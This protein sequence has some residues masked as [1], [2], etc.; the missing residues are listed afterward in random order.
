MKTTWQRAELVFCFV[1]FVLLAGALA[2]SLGWSQRAGLFPWIVLVPTLALTFWQLVDDERGKTATPTTALGEEGESAAL[3]ADATSG[4]AARR[5]AGVVAWILGFFAAII[6]LGFGVGGGL[7]STLYLRFAARERWLLSGV[8]G[9]ITLL[10]IE[11]GFRR[12]LAIPFPP[13][14]VFDWL[15]LD[16]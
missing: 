9:V 13:G 8:Y 6:V 1:L 3:E 4:A 14:M 10:V 5:G 11:I 2:T 15:G 7:L 12:L 16:L